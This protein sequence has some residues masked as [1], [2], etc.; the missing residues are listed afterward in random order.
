MNPHR[1]RFFSYCCAGLLLLGCGHRD[2]SLA[3]QG[4][5]IKSAGT[6]RSRPDF[7]RLEVSTA[8][9]V[10]RFAVYD[11]TGR[12]LFTS[13]RHASIHQRW[14]LYVDHQQRIWDASADIG[15]VVWAPDATGRYRRAAIT[16]ALG[17][18]IAIPTEVAFVVRDR[19]EV[20]RVN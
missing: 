17:Q 14:A 18:R 4:G 5:V 3:W 1:T 2:S 9:G 6:Y 20:Q 16:A 12:H 19:E 7:L 11:R 13:D 8:T 10:V 15:G